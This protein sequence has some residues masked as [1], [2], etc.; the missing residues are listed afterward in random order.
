MA[1]QQVAEVQDGRSF[2]AKLNA[3]EPV[4]RF[5]PGLSDRPACTDAASSSNDIGGPAPFGPAFG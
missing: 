3:C 2:I 1:F 4:H 5:A